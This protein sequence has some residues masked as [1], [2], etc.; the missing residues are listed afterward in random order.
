M[1]YYVY[2]LQTQDGSYYTGITKNLQ[3]RLKRHRR[4]RGAKF[5]K[6]KGTA[7]LVYFEE[8]PSLA[9]A[10][11]REKQI[12]DFSRR[13]KQHLIKEFIREHNKTR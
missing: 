4:K 2:I 7:E 1:I 10:M 8:H 6:G 9:A 13:K 3:D 11:K 5:T 12:K